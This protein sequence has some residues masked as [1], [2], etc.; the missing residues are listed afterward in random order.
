MIDFIASLLG[1]VIRFIYNLVGE[2]YGLSIILFTILTKLILFPINYK[3]S[4]AMKDMQK[5]A[6]LQEEIKQKYKG[7]KEKQ[8]EELAKAYEQYKIN[9]MAGCLPL[10]IQIPIILAMFYIVKQPLTYILQVPEEQVIEY[11]QEYLAKE[12]VSEREARNVEINIASEKEL[13]DMKFWNINFGDIPS[14][15]IKT[16]KEYKTSKWTLVIPILSILLS[17]LQSKISAKNSKM[18]EE[19]IQ[20]QKSM[21]LMMPFLSG[22][23]AYVMPIALGVYWLLG[24]VLGIVSQLVIEKLL[25]KN[26]DEKALLKEKN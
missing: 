16:D 25:N 2:N 13:M 19:Q 18:T 9:P 8:A 17:W 23:I 20:Q 1:E 3:Q 24:S 12:D 26:I 6:P 4:K 5:L 7:N 14:E 11:A 10:L 21:N 15:S 22:Y